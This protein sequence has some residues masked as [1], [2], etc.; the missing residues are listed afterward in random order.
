[1]P[2]TTERTTYYA[3]PDVAAAA[4]RGWTRTMAKIARRAAVEPERIADFEADMRGIDALLTADA[5]RC[6]CPRDDP[7]QRDCPVHGDAP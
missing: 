6:T 3:G 5:S 7:W 1:M 4:L 2:E